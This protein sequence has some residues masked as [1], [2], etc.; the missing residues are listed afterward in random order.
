LACVVALLDHWQS[1]AAGLLGAG[2]AIAAVVFTLRSEARRRQR[3]AGSLKA[4]LGVEI[5][6]FAKRAYDGYRMLAARLDSGEEILVRHLEDDARFPTAVVFRNI[7]SSLGTLGDYTHDVVLFYGQIQLLTDAIQRLG[8][9]LSSTGKVDQPTAAHLAD[10]LLGA[11]Q[12]AV[13][14]LPAFK[15]TPRSQYD[16]EFAGVVSEAV[17]AWAPKKIRFSGPPPFEPFA[18]GRPQSG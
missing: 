6:L 16:T 5:R 11:C 18:W 8:N 12:S 9:L 1:L 13:S 2:A 10:T 4:S 3:E 17:K 15:N 7:S 14:V